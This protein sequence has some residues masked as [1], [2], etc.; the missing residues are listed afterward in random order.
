[1]PNLECI[2]SF[3]YI[4]YIISA[5]NLSLVLAIFHWFPWSF[6]IGRKLTGYEAFLCGC[7]GI[8]GAFGKYALLT[9]N[10]WI[11]LALLVIL[12]LFHWPLWSLPRFRA[13]G[14]VTSFVAASIAPILVF[15]AYALRVGDKEAAVVLVGLYAAGWVAT[16]GF[17]Q[18][19]A[20]GEGNNALHI[21]DR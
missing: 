5:I 18:L 15:V 19:D 21:N 6:H 1:M 20:R 8:L 2:T 17:Y 10:F 7:L 11:W 12:I 13:W 3:P 14:R 9:A 4:A 16:V